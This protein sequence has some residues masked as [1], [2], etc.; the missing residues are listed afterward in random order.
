MPICPFTVKSSR[1]HIPFPYCMRIKCFFFLIKGQ[2]LGHISLHFF[3]TKNRKIF[4][5]PACP[6]IYHGLGI[7]PSPCI[8]AAFIC[9]EKNLPASFLGANCVNDA[10]RS[11]SGRKKS[12]FVFSPGEKKQLYC[13]FFVG[14]Y[15]LR[16]SFRRQ[17][18]V[19][20]RRKK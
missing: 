11:L 8:I 12:D 20:K 19:E 2:L 14:K 1:S 9:P 17:R 3:C 18:S 7:R 16:S 10:E 4:G 5:Q 6:K 13:A 15:R